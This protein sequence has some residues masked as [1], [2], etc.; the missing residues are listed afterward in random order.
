MKSLSVLVGLTALGFCLA[1]PPSN[2][3][4][5]WGQQQQQPQQS[6]WGQQQQQQ[7]QSSGGWGQQQQPQV[8]Q[9]WGQQ[10]QQ[11]GWGQQ[12]Q[13]PQQ[14]GGWGQPQQM[15]GGWGQQESS[16][17]GGKGGKGAVNLGVNF[18]LGYQGEKGQGSMGGGGGGGDGWSSQPE[19]NVKKPG[20]GDIFRAI[21]RIPR[22]IK[23]LFKESGLWILF[24]PLIVIIPLLY[25][26]F[27]AGKFLGGMSGWG[28]DKR[29]SSQQGLYSIFGIGKEDWDSLVGFIQDPKVQQAAQGFMDEFVV[30]RV[31]KSVSVKEEV[32]KQ[33]NKKEAKKDE[34]KK[35][36]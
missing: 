16:S 35:S 20:I 32:N 21:I 28:W 36:R 24:L 29:S 5:G 27:N 13:Q 2:N 10:M 14:S 9:G 18:A 7:Q 8:Q 11:M 15:Q 25:V 33:S 4:Q 31:M 23:N 22:E 12:Q 1:E 17:G 6:G 19:T 30:K 34:K 3:N 26:A